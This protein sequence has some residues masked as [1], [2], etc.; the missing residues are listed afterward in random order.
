[1]EWWESK[2]DVQGLAR[3]QGEQDRWGT[4]PK[5]AK[6]GSDPHLPRQTHLCSYSVCVFLLLSLLCWWQILSCF[7]MYFKCFFFFFLFKVAWGA[8]C[9]ESIP[10][11]LDYGNGFYNV[12]FNEIYFFF[13]SLFFFFFACFCLFFVLFKYLFAFFLP[14][15]LFLFSYC[16]CK[17]FAGCSLGMLIKPFHIVQ[18][19]GRNHKWVMAA[20]R[21]GCG[22]QSCA[23]LVLVLQVLLSDLCWCA[24]FSPHCLAAVAQVTWMY[25]K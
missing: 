22:M 11:R 7:C 13:C 9:A 5:L 17:I 18:L 14:A 2:T 3:H 25:H 21:Q 15:F 19:S 20:T 24:V 12:N 8:L 10:F 6:C 16:K 1:M 23:C 4:Q